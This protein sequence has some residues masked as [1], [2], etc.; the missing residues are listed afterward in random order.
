MGFAPGTNLTESFGGWGVQESYCRNANSSGLS[1]RQNCPLSSL[2]WVIGPA[3]LFAFPLLLEPIEENTVICKKQVGNVI[4][5]EFEVHRKAD[6]TQAEMWGGMKGPRR[7]ST[8]WV[9]KGA[10]IFCVWSG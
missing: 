6:R 1:S 3:S 8:R 10:E 4:E 2:R 7:E 5:V 9:G